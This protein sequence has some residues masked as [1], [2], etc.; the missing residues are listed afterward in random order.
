[1][2]DIK[3]LIAEDNGAFRRLLARYI[4][5]Y[6]YSSSEV[7]DGSGALE[8][9]EKQDYDVVIADI[10]MPNMSGMEL[11]EHTCKRFPDVDVVIITGDSTAYSY[12]D[13]IES[14]ASDF[15]H[16]PVSLDELKAK[17]DRI[18]RERK[19]LRQLRVEINNHKITESELENYKLHLES[20]VTQRTKELK[21]I[22]QLLDDEVQERRSTEESLLE[23]EATLKSILRATPVGI[24]L[25]ID[26]T[27]RWVSPEL[28]K[29]IGYSIDELIG[30]NARILY[31]ST[32]EFKRVGVVKYDQ[33][34]QSDVGEVETVWK[35]KDGTLIDIHLRSSPLNQDDFSEGVTF[36]ALDI[37][38][39]KQMEED[40]QRGQKLESLGL[41]AGGIA[42]DF[43]NLL[44]AIMGNLSLASLYADPGSQVARKISETEFA[45][46]RSK[47][48]TQQLLTFAR[49]GEPIKKALAIDELLQGTCSFSLKGSNVKCQFDF[50]DNLWVI[51]ADEG[52][53]NQLFQNLTINAD[54]AMPEGGLLNVK[55]E[56]TN[57]SAG[58]F[59]SLP[60]GHYL[61]VIFSDDGIGVGERYVK[62]MFDPYFTTKKKGKGLGLAVAYSIVK[63][64]NGLIYAK[65]KKSCGT[66]V[67]VYLPAVEGKKNVVEEETK[68]WHGKGK[69]LVMDD[70]DQV[71]RLAKEMLEHLGYSVTT[72]VNGEEAVL[73][74]EKAY[75]TDCP[76][77]IVILDL[78][79]P[80]G[81]GGKD[82]I[83]KLQEIDP[84]VKAVVSSGYAND[85]IMSNSEAYGFCAVMPKPYRINTLSQTLSKVV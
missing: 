20:I 54:Q 35:K 60:A 31:P 41:L 84:G 46:S 77:D 57:L 62:K 72:A 65:S 21:E 61:K 16:K 79:I 48:L 28:A 50:S 73:F 24:G 10:R 2:D 47:E 75:G 59:S 30:N 13:V 74:F 55:V 71:L 29:I 80:G 83:I 68:L 17:L 69:V 58:R 37:S 40:L 49:G 82:T 33:L 56:N 18:L 5:S 45:V 52:Q 42:H 51:E 3:I 38:S 36:T 44:Q 81:M 39:R 1:M 63:K 43:N 9:L 12:V 26:R 25:V 66:D 22:N 78:T 27:L 23:K 85:P 53:L 14:G 34:K 64:H 32:E 15:I 67:F 19:L 4:N 8:M 70:E 11:L 7:R 6:G 76:Y